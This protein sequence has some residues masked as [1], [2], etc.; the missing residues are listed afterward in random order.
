MQACLPLALKRG[1]AV[2][3]ISKQATH[4]T[5]INKTEAFTTEE[6]EV[7]GKRG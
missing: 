6:C 4:S 7:I 1:F 3:P 2:R 5:S